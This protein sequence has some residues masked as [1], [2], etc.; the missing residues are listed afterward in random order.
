MTEQQTSTDQASDEGQSQADSQRGTDQT[1]TTE[2]TSE[3]TQRTEQT[4]VK[5]LPGWAQKVIRDARKDA[6]SHRKRVQEFEDAQKT[7]SERQAEALKA[8]TERAASLEQ[9]IRDAN[10]RSVVADAASKAG[11]ISPGLMYRAVRDDLEFDDDGNPVN[12]ADVIDALKQSEPDQ[13]RAAGGS[14]DGGRGN[15]STNRSQRG[16][17]DLLRQLSDAR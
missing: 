1:Q 9:R 5:D 16:L 10:A 8:A 7:E 13:F 4:E 11:A 6:E 14:G 12:A 2:Q 15:E 17:N 3:S